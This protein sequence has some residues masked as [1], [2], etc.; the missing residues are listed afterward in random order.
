M[1][2]QIFANALQKASAGTLSIGEAIDIAGVLS[3]ANRIDLSRE[4]YRVWIA[5]NEGHP[6][7]FVAHFNC[8]ALDTQAGDATAAIEALKQAIA[9]NADFMP[10]YINLGSMLER[11]GAPDHAL[12]LWKTAITRPV[13][14]NGNMVAYASTALKQMA[15]V[16]SDRQ[17]TEAA[18]SVVQLCLDINPH[19]RDVVEQ[20]I[21]LRMAQCKWPVVVGRESLDRK[22][23]MKGIHPLSVAVYTDDPLLQLA[24]AERYSRAQTPD[25][26]PS[27]QTDRRHARVG[28]GERRL[29]VGYISSDL[30][31]HAI[32]YLMAEFFELHHK[33]DI[34][35]FAYYCGPESTSELTGRIKTAVEHWSDIRTLSDDE[36]ARTIAADQIDILVDVNGHTRDARTAIFARRPAPVQ[37]NWL[38]YP[39]TMGTPYHHYIIADDW[40]IPAESEIYYS[41]KV[42]RL[43]CYQPN[44]RKRVLAA[45]PT[46]FEAG[47]PNDA[48]VFCCFNGTHKIA[49]FTFERW[50]EILARVPDSVLWL[51]DTSAET[52][53]R[54]A[55]L[56][57]SKGISG[58]RLVF[59]PK[60]QN[61]YHLARY[62]LADLFLDTAPYGAHTTASDALWTGVPV[63]TLSGRSFASRVCGSLVR[64]AGL[65]GLVCTSPEQ[66]VERAV[67]LGNNRSH[68]Q[69]Y[70]KQLAESR[71]GC[72]LFDTELL[73][74][75]LEALYRTMARDHNAGK[76]P[77]PDLANLD[78]YLETGVEFEHEHSEMLAVADYHGL[79]KSK[80]AQR[81]LARPMPP[82]RRL[83]T[84][85]DVA[86]IEGS[87][88]QRAKAKRAATR[89][90]PQPAARQ[91]RTG[92]K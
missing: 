86:R 22:S 80:F 35:V 83:W 89:K 78:A 24:T 8:S 67:F 27:T 14:I 55:E 51:L 47:L 54:L 19:Q 59:A 32:G 88:F 39:G 71:D 18:E 3:A 84:R 64:A 2:E 87:E 25:T 17:Q 90:K 75:N 31:D 37:V 76:T 62:A 56:A 74:R 9:L 91:R 16:L 40:I 38:G 69:K 43:P 65:K 42:V 6:L 50:M 45:R 20:Y 57:E 48:F 36:A 15:R 10:A 28:L 52:K 53:K 41:E 63:L 68:I 46:R 70:K 72:T 60:L 61:S 44:D 30:R 21:A 11:A 1:P 5:H 34:E 49:R 79:Y 58:T 4:L 82:D 23:L 26:P 81:H 13:P 92:T 77:R 12:E 66:Y 7:R 29:R 73:V 85:D 33:K